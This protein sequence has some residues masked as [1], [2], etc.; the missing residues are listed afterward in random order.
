MVDSSMTKPA[1][2]PLKQ[3]LTRSQKLGKFAMQ[4]IFKHRSSADPKSYAVWYAYADRKNSSL[5]A[6]VD[7]LIAQGRGVSSAEMLQIYETH[8][9]ERRDSEAALEDIGLAIQSRVEGA[10]S[11]VKDVISNT[12]Q[13]ASSIDQ[14]ARRI[15]QATS[16]DEILTALDQ[17]MEDTESSQEIATK[18]EVALQGTHDEITQL[19]SKVGELRDTLKRDSLTDLINRPQF[20]QRLDISAAEALAN[21]YSLTVLVVCIKNMQ[22]LSLTA[23]GDISEYVLKS[24]SG[25]LTKSVSDK[26][27]C[28]RISAG[29]LAIMLPRFAYVDAGK[30]AKTITDELDNFKLVKKP[31]GDPVG[32]IECAFGGS[33]LQAGRGASELID[34]ACE[35][36][37]LAKFSH[38]NSVKF[39]L[40]SHG[41]AAAR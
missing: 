24:L 7:D 2:A 12:N 34:I 23:G 13:Y 15:P 33:A 14:A 10:K 30:I 38:K 36:A 40:A 20:E 37:R 39:D 28:A 1:S 21:G 18:I 26:G 16:P 3:P 29:E 41:A 22:D 9:S 6:L 11:L 8:L 4:L 17:L 19:N 27:V 5:V 31:S 35:Q 32:Y 25:F